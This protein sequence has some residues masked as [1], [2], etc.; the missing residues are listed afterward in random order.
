VKGSNYPTSIMYGCNPNT[1]KITV[2]QYNE[3]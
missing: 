1:S 2:T 3:G